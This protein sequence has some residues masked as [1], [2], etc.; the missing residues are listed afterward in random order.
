MHP[1]EL[2]EPVNDSLAMQVVAGTLEHQTIDVGGTT[3]E[4]CSYVPPTLAP[5]A[6]APLVLAFH[7]G[8]GEALG[9]AELTGLFGTADRYGF[10]L[11]VPQRLRQNWAN[12]SDVGYATDRAWT[13][14]ASSTR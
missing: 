10:V 9:F 8:G 2:F 7:G 11:M 13:T 12:G 5:D 3:R 4:C 14:S 1:D 6:A